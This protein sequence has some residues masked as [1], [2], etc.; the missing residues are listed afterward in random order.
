[1]HIGAL[2]SIA[3][4]AERNAHKKAKIQDERYATHVVARNT[5]NKAG[6]IATQVVARSTT[7]HGRR[8]CN[9]GGREE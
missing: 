5:E 1:M 4:A 3:D 2:A 6:S 8:Q 7:K 9:T